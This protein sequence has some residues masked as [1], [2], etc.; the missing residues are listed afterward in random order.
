MTSRPQ[1]FAFAEDVLLKVIDG[2]ALL[3][4]L[5]DEDVFAL[6]DSGARIAELIGEGLSVD[7][8]VDR[9]ADEYG[10]SRDEIS[11][12]VDALTRVLLQKGL[13][14]SRAGQP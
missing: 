6:N 1:G 13:L 7:D 11:R 8:L 10:A 3:V 2:D 4:K 9:L 5:T 12:D 14:V